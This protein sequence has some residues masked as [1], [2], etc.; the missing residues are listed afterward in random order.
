MVQC[1][2]TWSQLVFSFFCRQDEVR[3]NIWR[4][5]SGTARQ[6]PSKVLTC[7]VQTSQKGTEEMS[8]WSLIARRLPQW[9]PAGGEQRISRYLQMQFMH[10]YVQLPVQI[11]C[12]HLI[13]WQ[14]TNFLF[15]FFDYSNLCFLHRTQRFVRN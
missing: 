3:C 10:M 14:S 2:F 5:S 4:V 1:N 8:S 7:G 9:W 6:I 12:F 15:S 13:A 11:S